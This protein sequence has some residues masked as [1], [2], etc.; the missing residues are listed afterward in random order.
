MP[1][2][3]LASRG[4]GD[5]GRVTCP[6]PSGGA[7]VFFVGPLVGWHPRFVLRLRHHARD[8]RIAFWCGI[9]PPRDWLHRLHAVLRL[10][11]VSA[12]SWE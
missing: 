3:R 5:V 1:G 9:F 7:P 12:P 8:V 6:A 11:T 10:S 2:E 4:R